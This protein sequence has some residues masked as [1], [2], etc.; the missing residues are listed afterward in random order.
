ML[1]LKERE[2]ALKGFFLVAQRSM[3]FPETTLCRLAVFKEEN[4]RLLVC[5]GRYVAFGKERITILVLPME[6]RVS[7]LLAHKVH[8]ANHEEIAVKKSE[9]VQKSGGKLCNLQKSK[10]K[11]VQADHE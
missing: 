5:S 4:N 10:S 7:L 8:D 11:E 1:T 3:T 9:V 6:A 2:D